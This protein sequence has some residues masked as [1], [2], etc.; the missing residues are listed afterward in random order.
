MDRKL[1]K[2]GIIEKFYHTGEIIM[3]YVVGP[4]SGIPLVF[5]PG[6]S[7]TWEEYT[8]LLPI[9]ADKF[10]VYAVSLRGHGKSSW[11]PGKYTFNQLGADMTA[12]LKDIVGR[13]AIVI[14]NSS[15]GVLTAWLAANSPE[16]VKAIILEDPPLF[17]CEWPNIKTTWVFDEIVIDIIS[18]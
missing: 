1:K 10:H 7:V 17:R 13:P 14:G 18:Q 4:D 12:F 5:I 15:G 9:L 16:F 3:N 8:L 2:K 6:Q 11:T